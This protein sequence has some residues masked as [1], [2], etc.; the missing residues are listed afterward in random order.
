[1]RRRRPAAGPGHPSDARALPGGTQTYDQPESQR[2]PDDLL[3]WPSISFPV[4]K[5]DWG[6]KYSQYVTSRSGG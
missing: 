2:A 5:G 4:A 1:M 3:F 6:T